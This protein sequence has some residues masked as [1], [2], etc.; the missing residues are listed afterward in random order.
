MDRLEALLRRFAEIVDPG[1]EVSQIRTAVREMRS[2]SKDGALHGFNN[3]KEPKVVGSADH[4][5]FT[6]NCQEIVTRKPI[7]LAVR[8]FTCTAPHHPSTPKARAASEVD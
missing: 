2:R 4:L 3:K 5:L 8:A 1:P 7:P 6:T